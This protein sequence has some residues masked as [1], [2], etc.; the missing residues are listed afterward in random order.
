MNFGRAAASD[1][2]EMELA[3]GAPR[4]THHTDHAAEAA[5]IDRCRRQDLA[6]FGELVDAYQARVLGFVRRMV[7]NPD[8]ATDVTQ[9]VFIRAYQNFH[10]FDG[11]CSVRTWLFRIAHNLCIDRSRKVKRMPNEVSLQISG[12]IEEDFD[13]PD[14]RWEPDRVLM[15][16]E[17][18]AIIEAGIASMSEKLRSVL[19]LHD[20]EELAYD[21][22]AQALDI[23]V[24][25]VKS[26]LFLARAHLKNLLR[27]YLTGDLPEGGHA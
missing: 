15:S 26:R 16:D 11:R 10:R 12:E 5:M 18:H 20:R 4:L 23:P 27:P 17:L 1:P 2:K 7:P 9:E 25:T 13:A 8:D 14:T 22:I 21:E 19:I 6:A 24:G 3:L